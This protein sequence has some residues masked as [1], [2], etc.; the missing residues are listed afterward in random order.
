M[1]LIQM[2]HPK[3]RDGLLEYCE[4]TMWLQHA[5]VQLPRVAR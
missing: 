1:A 5:E 4:R 3:F 2:P